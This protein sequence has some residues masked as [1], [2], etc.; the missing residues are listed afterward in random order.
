MTHRYTVRTRTGF[1]QNIANSF[2]GA[3]IGLL[4]FVASFVVFWFNEGRVNPATVARDSLPLVAGAVDP[5]IDGRLVAVSGTLASSAMVGDPGLL[6]PGA[7][8]ALERKVY[9]YAWAERQE[10]RTRN[11][12]GGSTTRETVYVYEREWT[13]DPEDSSRF[14]RQGHVNPEMPIRSMTLKPAE[15]AIGAYRLDPALLT[16]P[17]AQTI[18]LDT[19]TVDLD[20]D[21]LL[22]GG[23][24]V[25]RS[26][27]TRSPQ[28]GD[29]RISY[30]AVPNSL[31]V[32][33]FARIAG[34]RL[35]PYSAEG[36]TLFRAFTADRET[37][38]GILDQEF[39]VSR[40]IVRLL[41]FGMMWV[42]LMLS[43]GPVT[44]FLNVLPALGRVTGCLFSVAALGF[45]LLLSAVTIVVA[46]VAHN[47]VLLLVLGGML[48]GGFV[49]YGRRGATQN[50]RRHVAR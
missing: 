6:R 44:S 30:G 19:T 5:A 24:I 43:L 32:T 22:E 14:R 29:L 31:L 48:V 3:L 18:G 25:S 28:I 8:L 1:L 41:C 40:W 49:L 46:T 21:W 35:V 7:Y 10:T 12:I 36:V 26:G 4:L 42:G 2:A 13:T 50:S 47:V 15:A 39:H 33:L 45:A 37:A 20:G 23:E 11:E 9:M 27:A 17:D 34:D 38:I 16:L